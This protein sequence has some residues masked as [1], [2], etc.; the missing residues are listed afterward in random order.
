MPEAAMHLR[1]QS[2][3]PQTSGSGPLAGR[4]SP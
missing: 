2:L 4:T 3:D 1:E